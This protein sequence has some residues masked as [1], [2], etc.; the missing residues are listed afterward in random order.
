MHCFNGKKSL[1]KRI[2]DNGWFLTVPAI[3]NFLEHFKMLV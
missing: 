2:I 1:I 3:I